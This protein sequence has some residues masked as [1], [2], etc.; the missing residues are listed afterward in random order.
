MS[1]RCRARNNNILR[2]KAVQKP[3]KVADIQ[4]RHSLDIAIL[5]CENCCFNS[6]WLVLNSVHVN[7]KL[8]VRVEADSA[9]YD[10]CPAWAPL[11]GWRNLNKTSWWLPATKCKYK[12]DIKNVNLPFNTQ[13]VFVT[14]G[15][16]QNNLLSIFILCWHLTFA[17]REGNQKSKKACH[18]NQAHS[19]EIL[20][21]VSNW[22]DLRLINWPSNF[23]QS[24][25]W[26]RCTTVRVQCFETSGA[27]S[28]DALGRT[29]YS[30]FKERPS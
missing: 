7:L 5:S 27:A 10:Q 22:M 2:T 30:F 29:L 3:Q 1:Q 8:S 23:W 24:T 16:T 15:I 20:D 13:A 28:Y 19:G 9:L 17:I 6:S 11:L 18:N 25:G 12:I 21:Q 26:P 14:T 4:W